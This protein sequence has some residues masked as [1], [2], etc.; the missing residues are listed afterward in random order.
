M[1]PEK[2]F[3]LKFTL[4]IITLGFVLAGCVDRISTLGG[5]YY[6]DTV[7]TQ[8]SIRND[9]G[10][11]QFFDT[12]RPFVT[13]SPDGINSLNGI[14]YTLTDS[15]TLMII[16]KVVSDANTDKNEN[17][18]S[19]GILK[20]PAL[21]Q[22]SAD[23]VVGVRLI[24]KDENFSYGDTLSSQVSFL[25]YEYFPPG[26]EILDT[27]S[28]L[29]TLMP[30]TLNAS[31]G[32]V[33]SIDTL[34]PDSSDRALEIPIHNTVIPDLTASSLVFIIAPNDQKNDMINARGFGT[35]HSYGDPN[36]VPQI[37]Y[38]LSN[39]DSVYDAPI[40]DLFVVHDM[41]TIPAGEFTLR[42]GT[43][44]RERI[45][46]HLTRPKDTAQLNAF[47]TINN[48]MLVLHIDPLYSA[49]SDLG[50]DTLG[51]D[52]VQL[53][54]VDS[55]GHFDGNGYPDPSD[56]SDGIYRFQVRG[57]VQNW[58]SDSA[59]NYGFELRSGFS[60]RSFYAPDPE[61]IGV[62]DNTL[63]RWT[64]YGPNCADTTKRP[65]FILSYS[66]LK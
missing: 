65:Y 57:L 3:L 17:L 1:T 20:F 25:V 15:T 51:P 27:V 6:T 59:M 60:S 62:E 61:T 42:G 16:G 8:T 11:I 32:Y 37:Q 54:E 13:T 55:G 36:S 21:S 10:F 53:G 18:E 43:G 7:G 12:L 19:W 22:D 14:D 34:F 28:A 58:L 64:F 52:I 50:T 35:I 48:G 33:G 38:Y 24:L 9:T 47:S 46:L 49:H 5:Q 26:Q 40:S 45:N 56:T 29:P 2:H 41:S 4:I 63:D 66:K 44:K 23:M 30:W 39:G 31:S